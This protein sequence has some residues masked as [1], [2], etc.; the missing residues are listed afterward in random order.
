M[1][2]NF[3]VLGAGVMQGPAIAA[4]RELGFNTI[5]VDANPRAACI[6]SADHFEQIDLADKERLLDFAASVQAKAGLAGVMTCGTDF[7]TSVAWI[8][9]RLGLS[10]HSYEAALNASDKGRMRACFARS[11]VPSP[12]FIT[13]NAAE[14]S[15]PRFGFPAVVKPVDSMGARG[16]RR[17]DSERELAAAVVD[18]VSFSRSGQAIIE[19]YMEGPEYSIDALVVDG[20]V[21]PAG[22]ADRHIFFPPYFIEMGHTMPTAAPPDVQ[23]RLMRAFQA[24]VR[25]LGLSCGAAK[26]DVKMTKNGPMIGEIAARLSGGYMS[27]WTYPLSSGVNVIKAAVLIAAGRGFPQDF[28][29]PTINRVSAERAFISIPGK[30]RAVYAAINPDEAVVQ[31]IAAVERLPHI[32]N[33]FL[34]AGSGDDVDFPRNNVSKCGNVISVAEDRRE[35]VDAADSAARSVIIRLQAPDARTEAFLRG[36]TSLAQAD[37]SGT[38]QAGMFPPDAFSLT[39]EGARLLDA[40]PECKPAGAP[41]QALKEA[42]VVPLSALTSSAA[43]DYAGRSVAYTLAAARAL[44]GFALPVRSCETGA[45]FFGKRFWQAFVRGGIQGVVYYLDSLAA[46][47]VGGVPR[48]G[49]AG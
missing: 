49:N 34:R 45:L 22:I 6:Q 8:T 48:S 21:I 28:S 13:V 25:A 14:G 16:C 31:G 32:T 2:E 10:G 1:R 3:L 27:G 33:L 12:S 41:L 46:G 18:A 36:Q 26:G 9:E 30:V 35:A 42:A 24:G 40:L 11:G 15:V 44:T 37:Q 20:R 43:V 29:Q 38:G 19:E 39:P 5:A 4:A 23:E 47:A 7:S 17:V